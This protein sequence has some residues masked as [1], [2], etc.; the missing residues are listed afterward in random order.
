MLQVIDKIENLGKILAL[1]DEDVHCKKK[2]MQ[3]QCKNCLRTQD[4][5]INK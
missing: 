4:T 2:G 1:A 5:H 3:Q